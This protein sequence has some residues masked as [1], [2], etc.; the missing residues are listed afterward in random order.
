MQSDGWHANTDRRRSLKL[1]Q[2]ALIGVGRR[3]ISKGLLKNAQT[4]SLHVLGCHRLF[5]TPVDTVSH[6][7][8]HIPHHAQIRLQ[9]FTREEKEEQGSLCSD[10]TKGEGR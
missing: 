3:D 7:T 9:A 10:A 5:S 2:T 8:A 1:G 6:Q 4:P